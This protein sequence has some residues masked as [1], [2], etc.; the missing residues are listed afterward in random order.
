M[1]LC[2]DRKAKHAIKSGPMTDNTPVVKKS[3]RRK[4]ATAPEATNVDVNTSAPLKT[5]N[6]LL[7]SFSELIT[8]ISQEKNEL[9]SLQKEITETKETWFKEQKSHQLKNK[10]QEEEEELIRKRARE[11]YEYETVLAHKKTEDEFNEK[12]LQWEKELK[13]RREEIQKD[14]EELEQ[15]RKLVSLFDSDKEKAVKEALAI[16]QKTL[17]DK[18]ETEKK[19]REQEHNSEKELLNLKITSLSVENTRQVNEIE[20]LKKS[21]DEATRQVKEIAVKVI[22]SGGNSSKSTSQN[23]NL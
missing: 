17:T 16:L 22:E 13:D 12:K 1:C 5:I 23:S 19:M 18:F 20:S 2:L 4:T 15:L 10:E 11:A 3:T 9:E 14:K 7:A 6:T 21:L 8:K